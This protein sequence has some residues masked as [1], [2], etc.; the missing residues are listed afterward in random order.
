VAAERP[1]EIPSLITVFLGHVVIATVIDVD[2]WR[3]LYLLF[4]VLWGAMAADKLIA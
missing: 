1:T 2:D 3:H 4:C